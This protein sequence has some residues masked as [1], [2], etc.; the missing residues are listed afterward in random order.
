MPLDQPELDV[1]RRD[2]HVVLIGDRSQHEAGQVVEAWS[3]TT[4]REA[5]GALDDDHLRS[6]PKSDL[7]R[8]VALSTPKGSEADLV[9]AEADVLALVVNEAEPGR[10]A[11]GC[12]AGKTEKL[13]SSW[14]YETYFIGIWHYP[15]ERTTPPARQGACS[16][17][18]GRR[19]ASRKMWT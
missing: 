15:S 7:N 14:N 18:G 9:H 10:Q 6:N 16:V 5:A 1:V 3:F 13:R 17:S 8:P 11:G 2:F 4:V 12:H 19:A